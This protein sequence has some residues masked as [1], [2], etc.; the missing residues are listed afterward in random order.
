MRRLPR[1]ALPLLAA[2]CATNPV[3]GERQLMLVSE[4]QEIELGKQ[5]AEEVR[6]SMPRY[7]DEKVQ[8]YVSSVG[9]RMAK[10]SERPNLP[11]SFTVVDDAAVNAFALPGGPIFITRGI[12]TH[13][14]SEAELASVLGHEI[15][16]VTARHSV[17]QLSKQQL[18]QLGLGIGSAISPELAGV[19]QAGGAGLKLLFLKYGRD[20]ESQA[21]QLGFRYMLKQSWDPHE[22]PKMFA[23]LQRVSAAAGGDRL[24]GYLATHPDP[25]DREAVAQHRAAEV[26]QPGLVVHRDEYLAMVNGM[27]YGEDPRHGFFQGNT[28]VHPELKFRIDL[29]EGWK[30]QNAPASVVAISPN[31]DALV[32]LRTAGKTPPE[33]AAKKFLAQKGILPA[34]AP[35][36]LAGLPPGSSYFQAVTEQGAIAGLVSFVS[37]GGATFGILGFTEASKLGAQ[38]ATFRKTVA[39]FAELKDPALL[40]VQA[41]KL[42]IVKVPRDMTVAEFVQQNPSTASAD[43]VATINGLA[44]DGRLAAGQQAKRLVGGVPPPK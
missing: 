28:F 19:A 29:P 40:A 17:Q 31:E 36:S 1:L 41:P 7:P 21:D 10:A 25:G 30:K 33:E 4:S 12:L 23:T 35:A 39:S 22:M 43:E 27:P 2:A 15:G 34:P 8:A 11:W 3:T 44:K 20:A 42:Q 5:S 14:N 32:Q 9:M 37:H 24:P 18:T 13:M 38:D 26:K 6:Q 16:H